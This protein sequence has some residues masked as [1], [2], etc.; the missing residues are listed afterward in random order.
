MPYTEEDRTREQVQLLLGLLRSQHYEAKDSAVVQLS[1]IGPSVVPLL[2][3]AL[4]GPRAEYSSKEIVR[5]LS[6]I[7]TKEA[8]EGLVVPLSTMAEKERGETL[9]RFNVPLDLVL[10]S[11]LDGGNEKQRLAAVSLIR[12]MKVIKALNSLSEIIQARKGKD[13]D[14]LFECVKALLENG[15]SD[16]AK[17]LANLLKTWQTVAPTS[18]E[19]Y[20]DWR[21][22]KNRWESIK[23]DV[24]KLLATRGEESIISVLMTLVAKEDEAAIEG[25]R[26]LGDKSMPHLLKAVQEGDPS[27]QRVAAKI[28]A[29]I[30]T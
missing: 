18:S 24:V 22:E 3:Q 28:I 29:S 30:K 27:L 9:S 15:S 12:D 2:V 4:D 1:R 19:K 25:L 7:G 5:A 21:R 11:L 20:S 10:V 6:L 13:D 23:M 8:L 26:I 14:L 16:S 17:C